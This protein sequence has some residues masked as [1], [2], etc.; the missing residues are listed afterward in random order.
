VAVSG[1]PEGAQDVFLRVYSD[2]ENQ[3]ASNVYAVDL[4]F[5]HG[6]LQPDGLN[7][8]RITS[9]GEF[10]VE[11]QRDHAEGS[12]VS[13]V[14]GVLSFDGGRIVYDTT[15]SRRAQVAS[16]GASYGG[17]KADHEITADNT[18]TSKT[19][20]NYSGGSSKSYIVMSFSGTGPESLRFLA[21]AFKERN[22][23]GGA[24]PDTDMI[25]S[26]EYRDPF[27]A[28]SPGSALESL[29]DTVDLGS[30]PFYA[31]PPSLSI[32]TSAFS[33]G[34]TPDIAVALDFANP[35][36]AAVR[37]VCE[38]GHTSERMRFCESD[39]TV[40]AAQMALP[41]TCFGPH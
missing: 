7:T 22:N 38:N 34:A 15:R 6:G 31:S 2:A 26:T 13:T 11:E 17:F 40:E 39:P 12:H 23:G 25:G 19:Y 28:A 20:G 29:L 21:G 35:A 32:D 41:G 24:P 5:C 10:T 4:W 37:T 3:A 33:C 36:A 30:D 1:E 9:A 14:T 18:I 8:I 16:A 27:Y